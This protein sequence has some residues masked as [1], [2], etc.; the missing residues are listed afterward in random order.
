M[1]AKKNGLAPPPTS[2][3]VPITIRDVAK[4]AGVAT[5][6][7]SNALNRPEIVAENT[8]RRVLAAVES[9]GLK[10]PVAPTGAF[11]VYFDV[12]STH[13]G[14]WEFCERVLDEVH[15][16]L[17]PGMDFGASTGEQYVRLSYTVSCDDLVEG[18]HRLGVFVRE[19][20]SA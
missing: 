19:V 14:S 1:T 16:A 13:L 11:Y 8:R 7:V 15:V 20:T 6:T 12:S 18:L 2:A 3:W 4:M 9:T 10:V 5:G 17:T